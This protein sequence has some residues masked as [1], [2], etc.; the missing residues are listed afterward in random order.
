M[1]VASQGS[2][3][4]LDGRI[5]RRYRPTNCRRF[6]SAT[7]IVERVTL[8]EVAQKNQIDPPGQIVI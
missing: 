1:P 3:G 8:R 6:K 7:K 2:P 4:E 5:I